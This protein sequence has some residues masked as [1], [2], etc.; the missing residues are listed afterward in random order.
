MDVLELPWKCQ[1]ICLWNI[2][3]HH[4]KIKPQIKRGWLVAARVPHYVAVWWKAKNT[5]KTRLTCRHRYPTLHSVYLKDKNT[6]KTWMNCRRRCPKLHIGLIKN[7]VATRYGCPWIVLK[8]SWNLFMK[9]QWPPWKEKNA[10]KTW[11]TCRHIC[12]TVR[13]HLITR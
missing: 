7:R 4:E 13:S 9:F 11:L 6:N 2:S 8:M 3:G 5:N 12:P 1:G 10:N